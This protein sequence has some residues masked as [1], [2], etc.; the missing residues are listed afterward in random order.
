MIQSKYKFTSEIGVAASKIAFKTKSKKKEKFIFF[1]VPIALI[2]MIA[3][4]IYD[5][6]KDNNIVMDIILIGLLIVLVGL[7]L[8]MPLLIERS[9]RKYLSQVDEGQFDY[10]ISEYDKGKFKE[11]LYKD[12][13]MLYCNE[14]TIDKLMSFKEFE[15]NGVKY[16]MVL[17]T[18]YISLVFD[19]TAFE[20]GSYEDL[21]NICTKA[22][23]N[24]V[25]TKSKK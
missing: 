8:F 9:Q 4:L 22:L 12:N 13:K 16:F 24:G 3:I 6:K 15:L 7:N 18:N 25:K 21:L 2:I 1:A 11:K 23:S 20:T 19:T 14:I 10:L 5:I 17:F